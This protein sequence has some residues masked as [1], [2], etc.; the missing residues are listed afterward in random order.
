MWNIIKNPKNKIF[1]LSWHKGFHSFNSPMITSRSH[2]FFDFFLNHYFLQNHKKSTPNHNI[3]VMNACRI[4]SKRQSEGWRVTTKLINSLYQCERW[5]FMWSQL[6]RSLVSINKR[7]RGAVSIRH[8]HM[9]ME[10]ET[11]GP[12][13]IYIVFTFGFLFLHFNLFYSQFLSNSTF[14]LFRNNTF[15]IV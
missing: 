3:P 4:P 5:I 13:Y 14:S 2:F 11:D 9:K 8:M 15:W 10:V 6:V 1:T 12:F 7:V